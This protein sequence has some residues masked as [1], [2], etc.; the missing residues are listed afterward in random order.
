MLCKLMG[1]LAASLCL[2]PAA[3]WAD[4]AVYAMTNALDNNEVLVFHRAADGSLTPAQTIATGGGGS[5]LQLIPVDSLGSAGSIRLDSQHR[6]LFVVNTESAAQNDGQGA[7]NTDCKQGTITSFRVADD[8][9]LTFADRVFSG[10]LYPNSIAVRTLRRGHGDDDS[11]DGNSNRAN[12]T[13]PLVDLLYVLNAG[14]PQPPAICHLTPGTANTPNI[15]GFRVDTTGHLIPLDVTQPIDPGNAA[16]CTASSS[17]GFSGLLGGVPVA[18]FQCGLNPPSFPRSPAQVGLSPD[19]KHLVVT[20]KATNT[21]YVFPLDKDGRAGAPTVTPAAP[22][23]LPNFTGFAFDRS[24]NLLVAEAFGA[25]TSIPA[26]GHAAVSSFAITSNGHLVPISAHVS[27]GGGTDAVSIAL[28][29]VTERFAYVANNLGANGIASYIVANGAVTLLSPAAA[30]PSPSLP[31]DIATATD[32][33]K[34][35]PTSFLYVVSPGDGTVRAFKI[36]LLNG[37][38]TAIAGGV[39]PAGSIPQGLAAY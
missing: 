31:N 2:L 21:I 11:A 24:G 29:P 16:N 12:D 32:G 6:F 26:G 10:G 27:D 19:G 13:D 5:G 17:A 7:Y 4:G 25:S 1:P 18:D 39:F 38:L 37:A 8:G 14:G 9:T 28:E 15:T 22:P 23:A 34:N 30:T 33:T 35:A 20:V 36:N 3:A